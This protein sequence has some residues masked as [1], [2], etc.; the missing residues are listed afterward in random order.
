MHYICTMFFVLSK[1]L[2]FLLSP[3]FWLIITTAGAFLLKSNEWRK[4][5]KW[6]ALGIFLFFS[7]S[8]IFSEVCGL[9]EI[10]GKR[11]ESVG[12]YDVGIVLGGMTEY[13]GDVE[14]LSTRRSGDRIFQALS[15]YHQGHVKKLFISGDSGHITD[16]GLHEARQ[17]KAILVKWGIP[18]EDILTEEISKNTYQNARETK[19]VLEDHPELK[20]YLLITSG[21]HM[22]RAMGCFERQG[23][24]CAPFSTDHYVNRT[25][26]YRWDQCIIPNPDNFMQW[27]VLLKEL[28]GYVVYDMRGYI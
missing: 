9:W 19:K 16:R 7:N 20:T 28:V 18:E 12:H 26:Q 24:R 13:N 14:S 27:N 3:F 21:T 15:L 2:L 11:I 25:G 17:M 23:L 5:L 8:V 1:A 22:R 10:P 6:I 4:R